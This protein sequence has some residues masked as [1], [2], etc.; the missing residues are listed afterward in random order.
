MTYLDLTQTFTSTMPVYPG[1]ATPELKRFDEPGDIVAYHVSTGMHVGTHMD[2]PLH[3]VANG[4]RLSEISLDKFFGLG[5]LVDARGQQTIGP[6]LLQNISEGDVVL[7]LTGFGDKFRDP[8]YY[9]KHPVLTEGFA[10][11]L[12]ELKVKIVGTDTPSPD[13]EPFSVHKILLGHEILILENLTNLEKLV[14]KNFEVV[15][16]PVKF[17]TEAAPVRVVA[18][19]I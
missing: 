17:E 11:R 10:K 6:E 9:E 8:D 2:A 7:V 15:A 14:N 1:D 18:K 16:L 3:M 4:K 13:R 12:V 5:K 19:I